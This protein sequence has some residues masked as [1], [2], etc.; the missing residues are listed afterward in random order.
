VGCYCLLSQCFILRFIFTSDFQMRSMS[1]L[2]N[3]RYLR[4]CF[5]PSFSFNFG[6]FVSVLLHGLHTD[7]SRVENSAQDSS[8]KLSFKIT[9]RKRICVQGAVPIRPCPGNT[10]K[11]ERLS[12][13]D[14]LNKVACFVKEDK[15]FVIS[16]T[17]DIN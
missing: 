2:S 1:A 14:L 16:K 11:R 10:N 13:V 5:G 3:R 15:M 4:I 17:A 8:Y 7:T 9:W 12:T 6:S